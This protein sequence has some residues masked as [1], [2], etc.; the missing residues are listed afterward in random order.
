MCGQ[1]PESLFRSSRDIEEELAQ[2][3]RF[4]TRRLTGR[5]SRRELRDI[6]DVALG[7]PADIMRCERCGVLVRHA[8]P[9]DGC[10]RDDRYDGATLEA[11][12][13][14]HVDAFRAKRGDYEHLLPPRAR[15]IEI[16]SYAGGFLRAA[17]EWG[18]QIVGIDIGCDTSRF[19]RAL[20]FD[21]RT[22]L[23]IHPGA[24]DAAFIWN[25][26]EQLPEPR[27]LLA[28][29]ARGLAGGG[30]LVLRVPDAAFYARAGDARLLAYNGLLGWPHRFGFDVRSLRRLAQQCGLR[31]RRILRTPAMR[32]YR[33]AT[34]PWAR[35]EESALIRGERCG[36]I[37]LTFRKV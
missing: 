28:L 26:F 14:A 9:D 34:K 12:H 31:L 4:F 35:A 36:W 25:C 7:T 8:P 23:E 13:A 29:I 21:T 16:G 33:E 2:R 15:V 22:E 27:A 6:T 1:P 5:A 18:W 3:D 11:L 17:S 10:F 20:G 24:L 19:T 37:E 32:P 30:A